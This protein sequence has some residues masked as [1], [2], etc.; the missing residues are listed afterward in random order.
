MA[1][2]LVLL[3]PD[4][5][6]PALPEGVGV[7]TCANSTDVAAALAG[8]TGGVVLCVDGLTGDGA[9]I[10]AAV[11]AFGGAAIEVKQ[12]AWDGETHS[13]VSAACAGTIAGFGVAGLSAAVALLLA[14]A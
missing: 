8:A 3:P 2:V 4:V 1:G 9:E 11:T 10:A 14:S 7:R 6:P 5:A 13:V 12:S